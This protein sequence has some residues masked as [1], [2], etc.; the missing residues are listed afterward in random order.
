M[1]PEVDPSKMKSPTLTILSMICLISFGVTAPSHFTWADSV[2]DK[3]EQW[4]DQLTLWPG[5]Q[6]VDR[7]FHQDLSYRLVLSELKRQAATTFGEQE[8]VIQGR[9][10]R[11]AWE[12][13]RRLDLDTLTRQLREQMPNGDLLYECESLDCGSSHF[14][15]NEIFDNG[16]LVGRDRYQRYLVLSQRVSDQTQ[17]V[18]L[19]YATYRGSR[20]TVIGINVVETGNALVKADVSRQQ[21]EEILANSSG[22]LPGFVVANGGLDNQA[23]DALLEVI[24]E[25]PKGLRKRLF[26]TVHCFEYTDMEEN[27]RCS[28]RLAEQLR[29]ATYDGLT[30]LPIRG[31]GALVLPEHSQVEPAVRFVFW[32]TRR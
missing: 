27:I 1:Q 19:L 31:L 32:P 5:T 30:E 17:R 29:V 13:S 21:I 16:R 8:R 22:W 7:Q 3:P 6:E 2:Y 15:A 18:Y 9:V 12:I 10:W 14:W 28:E 26:L 23:S 25:L 24:R 4:L 20:Q 11:R